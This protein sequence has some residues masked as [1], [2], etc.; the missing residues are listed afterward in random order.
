MR[1]TGRGGYA[2]LAALLLLG[3]AA[4]AGP[5]AAATAPAGFS[6]TVVATLPGPT[7]LAWTPDG[8]MLVTQQ[9]GL[10]R[11]VRGGVLN[12][13]PALDLT[14]RSCNNSE[15]G[16]L[17]VVVDP[18]F[19]TNRFVYLY[20]TH[21][22]H[23]TCETNTAAAPENRVAR[24]VLGDGDVVDPASETVIVDHIPSP[25]GNHNGGDMHFGADGLLYISVGDGGCQLTDAS[26]CQ[27]LNNNSRRLDIP[28]GKILRVT[29]TGAVPAS[30]PYAG[31]TGARRCTAPAGV[32]P[33]TGPCSETYASGFRNPF[34][35]AQRPGTSTFY[36][37]DVGQNTWEEI[38]SL[39]AGADYGWNVREGHCATDSTTSCG[40]SAYADPIYDYSH[41]TG[42]ES[43][44]GGAFVPTGLWPAPYSGAYLFSDYVCGKVFRLA[45]RSGGGY[46]QV[47]FLDGLGAKSAVNLAFGPYQRTSA[48]YYTTY[49]G[50]GQVRRVAYSSANSA[51]VASF[52]TSLGGTGARTLTADGS[53]SYDPDGGDSVVKWSW[54]FGDGTSAVTTTPRTT[55]TYTASGSYAVTLVVTDSHG[56]VSAPGTRTVV[57]G[58]RPPTVSITSPS[59]SAR[60][61]VGQSVTVA[62]TATDPED[63][64][65]PASSISWTIVRVHG[66]H[67][68]PWLGG[69]TGSSV[70]TTYPAPEDVA[71]TTDSWLRVTA[72]ARDSAGVSTRVSRRLLPH[73]VTLRLASQPS[74]AQLRLNEMSFPA[75]ADV[76]SW[77]GWVVHL[78]APDQSIGGT[79]YLF[80]FWSD[81]GAAAHDVT[82]PATDRTYT[83]TFK[84]G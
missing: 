32:P 51:P 25:N 2:G 40:P 23:A 20:W 49:G 82:T 76:V 84:R 72:V 10:L 70:T 58:N 56:L 39:T 33:G 79:P 17:S 50:G 27:P 38:D 54:D 3:L 74:G 69:V 57:A 22:A 64:A 21:N 62:A 26:R 43:I 59:T 67:T 1:R 48:L 19:A 7:G 16:V 8:R 44:T 80:D 14:A 28:L 55:H 6:D 34:R 11:V 75:P 36:V 71:S 15:R 61:A 18:A 5:A 29:S 24:Y 35:F 45:P 68:H 4:A 30:N 52:S 31:A 81:G 12:A 63:G 60:F 46:R 65:L 13:T 42:C 9:A 37:N 73:L 83:A 66:S 77:E 78:A 47:P 41:A 53:A